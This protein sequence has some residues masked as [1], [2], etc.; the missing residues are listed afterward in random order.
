MVEEKRQVRFH[1][2]WNK[3]NLQS[4]ANRPRGSLVLCSQTKRKTKTAIPTT[5]TTT[6]KEGMV[7]DES[8]FQQLQKDRQAQDQ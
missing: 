6:Y 3:N 1:N 5:E 2:K 8:F 4:N 7:L